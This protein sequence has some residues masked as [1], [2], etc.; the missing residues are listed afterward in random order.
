MAAVMA[1]MLLVPTAYAAPTPGSAKLLK[2]TADYSK[3]K[4]LQQE[5]NSGPG[6]IK[7]CLSC[8]TQAAKQKPNANNRRKST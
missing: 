4:A 6:V 8:H 3:F 7:A 2:S 1:S 5:F